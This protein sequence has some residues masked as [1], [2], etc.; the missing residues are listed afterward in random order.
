M[1]SRL[2]VFLIRVTPLTRQIL[3]ESD[4]CTDTGA[5]VQSRPPPGHLT[6]SDLFTGRTMTE[7][8]RG[9]EAARA[10]GKGSAA[11]FL[12]GFQYGRALERLDDPAFYAGGLAALL[13]G[14]VDVGDEQPDAAFNFASPSLPSTAVTT[15]RPPFLRK[16]ATS[17]RTVLESST[18]RTFAIAVFLSSV[19]RPVG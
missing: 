1:S 19:S 13:V 4:I 9:R 15:S 7:A 14:H 12:K 11:S 2:I 8:S 6:G 18:T 16:V 5:P 3:P 10:S 17:S